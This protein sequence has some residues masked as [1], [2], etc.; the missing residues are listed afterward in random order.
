[1][2]ST[3]KAVITISAVFAVLFVPPLFFATEYKEAIGETAMR[4]FCAIF[5]SIVVWAVFGKLNQMEVERERRKNNR[6]EI[7]RNRM[8]GCILLLM[9]CGFGVALAFTLNFILCMEGY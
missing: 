6:A 7:A 1:M 3:T 8:K 5:I 2:K 4:S 9:F